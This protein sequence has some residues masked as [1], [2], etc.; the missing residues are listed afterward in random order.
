MPDESVPGWEGPYAVLISADEPNTCP[1]AYDQIGIYRR[2]A[3]DPST[4]ECEVPA[5]ACTTTL[6]LHESATCDDAGVAMS[7]PLDTCQQADANGKHLL[8][9]FSTTGVACEETPLF[10]EPRYEEMARVCN[11]VGTYCSAPPQVARRCLLQIGDAECPD[12]KFTER[13]QLF[14]ND[15]DTRQ[16]DCGVATCDGQLRWH[17]PI[18]TISA[19]QGCDEGLLAGAPVAPGECSPIVSS[20]GDVVVKFSSSVSA[21]SSCERDGKDAFMGELR[22]TAPVTLCCEP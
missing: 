22:L 12:S 8:A 1:A 15:E 16:C 5:A 14:E 10:S 18:G 7:L 4:C 2:G 13:H 3:L 6:S 11:C 20:T 21:P 9:Q 17:V 19:Q